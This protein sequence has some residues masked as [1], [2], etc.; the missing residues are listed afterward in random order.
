MIPLFV[1]PL[2]TAAALIWVKETGPLP[3]SPWTAYIVFALGA[4]SGALAVLN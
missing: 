3:P 1:W 2:V 4:L